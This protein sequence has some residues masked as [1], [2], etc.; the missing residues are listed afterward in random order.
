MAETTATVRE[1]IISHG[2]IHKYFQLGIF[3]EISSG[4]CRLCWP[5]ALELA[6]TADVFKTEDLERDGGFSSSVDRV[7]SPGPLWYHA[8]AGKGTFFV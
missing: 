4:I 3:L 6:L 5:W 2:W 8:T 7:L 1:Q